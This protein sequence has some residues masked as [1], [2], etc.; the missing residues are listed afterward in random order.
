MSKHGETKRELNAARRELVGSRRAARAFM[1]LIFLVIAFSL[2]FLLRGNSALMESLGFVAPQPDKV[3]PG[4]TVSGNT[5]DSLS[6]RVAEVQGILT[7]DGVDEYNLDTATAAVLNAFVGDIDDPY[8]R[9]LDSA[10]YQTYLRE[11]AQ[12]EYVGI[13]VLL[14]ER[15]TA[16]YVADV[17]EGSVAAAGGIQM[18]DEVVSVDGELTAG[19]TASEVNNAIFNEAGRSVVLGMRRAGT[20]ETESAQEYTTTLVCSKHTQKNVTTAIN[21]GVGYIGVAQITQNSSDLVAEAVRSL[22]AAGAEALVLD[23]RNCP[24][25]YVSQA[26]DMA[27]L[28]INSGNIVQIVTK[29]GTTTKAASGATFADMPL[30]VLANENTSGAAE[31][32]AAALKDSQR[33]TLVGTVTMGKGSVQVVRELSFGGALR[34]TA[35][36]YKSPLGYA[37]DGVGVSPDITLALAAGSDNQRELAIDIASSRI[38]R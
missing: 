1:G 36:W 31:V 8:L 26:V 14:A 20:S 28:F 2:G 29:E 19:K 7:N 10:R 6:A 11:S 3:N 25:G 37:I 33:A 9:Y 5:Y 32:V 17:F 4:M 21:E 16:V 35:A 15:G 22:K 34:Y 27:N 12:T 38:G 13:G 30:V 18:G 24:G 23:L